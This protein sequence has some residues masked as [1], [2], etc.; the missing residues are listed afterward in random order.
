[1]RGNC[2][3][4]GGSSIGAVWLCR[5]LIANDSLFE[6]G[7][8]FGLLW[9]V[10]EEESGLPAFQHTCDQIN[11]KKPVTEVNPGMLT[12]T[13]HIHQ[14]GNEKLGFCRSRRTTDMFES[15][16]MKE[17]RNSRMTVRLGAAALA[18]DSDI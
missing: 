7:L 16:R 12:S 3:D 18:A 2:T 9:R 17:C 1:M 6:E 8:R 11:D 10:N 5:H 14:G 13:E 15:G 4:R